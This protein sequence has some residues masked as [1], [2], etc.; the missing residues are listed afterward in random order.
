[1]RES[2]IL[3][4]W[5]LRFDGH[6]YREETRF[7]TSDFADRFFSTWTLEWA[8]RMDC[9]AAFFLWQRYL[10][11]WGGESLPLNNRHWRLF[12]ELFLHTAHLEVPAQYHRDPWVGEC[13]RIWKET[14]SRHREEHLAIVGKIHERTRYSTVE[15]AHKTRRSREGKSPES[16]HV[17]LYNSSDDD[18]RTSVWAN[19]MENGDLQLAG[20]D[21]GKS[22]EKWFGSDHYEYWVTVPA[23][24]KDALL[25]ALLESFSHNSTRPERK[26][27]DLLTEKSIPFKFYC[28]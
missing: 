14:C 24:Q 12:R 21:L 25:L 10:Y 4:R 3:M 27:Q 26:L 6:L 1:M 15:P 7:D 9:L 16:K 23:A 2:E 5:A 11:K 28:Y 13:Y 18:P 22:V 8:D 17:E 20:Q 19:V